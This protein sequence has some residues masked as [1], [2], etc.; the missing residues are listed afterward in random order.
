[1][2]NPPVPL[3]TAPKLTPRRLQIMRFVAA[4]M[5]NTEIADRLCLSPNTIKTQLAHTFRVLRA[6]NRQHAVALCL[7]YELIRVEELRP[8]S[9]PPAPPAS[10]RKA[11]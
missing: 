6:R 2:T 4:G 5:E 8:F 10:V 11:A 9:L 1:M 7:R 3:R